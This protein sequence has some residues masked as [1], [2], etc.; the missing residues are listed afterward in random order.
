[1]T[2]AILFIGVFAGLF[3]IRGVAATVFFYFLLPQSDRCP[4]CDAATLRVESRGLNFLLPGLR[5]SWCF[6]C[7]WHGLLRLEEA[8]PVA[9]AQEPNKSGSLLP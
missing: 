6:E 8:L 5:S 7:D 3:V 4:N 9:P 2:D 1:M